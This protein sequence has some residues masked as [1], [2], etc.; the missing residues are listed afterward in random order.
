MFANSNDKL[1][2]MYK[3]FK[4][5]NMAET[6][7]SPAGRLGA[8]AL[9][10]DDQLKIAMHLHEEGM[11]GVHENPDN[12]ITLKSGRISPHYLDMRPG[13]SNVVTRGIIAKGL[14]DL[15]GI[16]I[17]SA[18]GEHTEGQLDHIVGTPEAFTSYAAT[19]ADISGAS[20]L[21]PR[22]AKKESGNKTPILGRFSP[23]DRVALFD[24]VV[25]DGRT[26]IDAIDGLK[27]AGLDV[28]GYFVVLDRQ[29]GGVP[30]V[31][32]ETE[33]LISSALRVSELV[34][35]LRA[36][37]VYSATQFDNVKQYLEQHGDPDVVASM[38]S[39]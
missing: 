39:A 27:T 17:D 19:M 25:T 12:F 37:N 8:Q 31:F 30:Q 7:E 6:G 28:K 11:F 9:P 26:K 1:Q 16:P 15:A 14:L 2:N 29:E 24:D 21:Q 38:G 34:K 33:I 18:S 20:L 3:S 5:G 22:V 10:E 36:E 35:M 32:E 23:G 4:E 13:I